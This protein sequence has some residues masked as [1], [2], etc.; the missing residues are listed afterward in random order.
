M[1]A[2]SQGDIFT[3]LLLIYSLNKWFLRPEGKYTLL[4]PTVTIHS[5]LCTN[6]GGR[7]H[8]VPPEQAFM[9]ACDGYG[10]RSKKPSLVK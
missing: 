3:H 2:G 7:G 10:G 5:D 1:G 8:C 4:A 9:P 6:G